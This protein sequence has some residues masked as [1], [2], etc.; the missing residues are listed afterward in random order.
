MRVLAFCPI[1]FVH[2]DSAHDG[3]DQIAAVAPE[4]SFCV[5]VHLVMVLMAIGS[6]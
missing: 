6:W 4:F 3:H 2:V 1:L 5:V